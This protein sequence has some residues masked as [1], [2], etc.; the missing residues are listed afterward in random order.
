MQEVAVSFLS[1]MRENY[2]GNLAARYGISDF[3][4][5]EPYELLELIASKRGMLLRKGEYDTERAAVML[6]D[7]FRDGK[8]GKIT[9]D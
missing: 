4:D 7:E 9:L 1:F 8:L 5:L 6:L 3:D 2:P